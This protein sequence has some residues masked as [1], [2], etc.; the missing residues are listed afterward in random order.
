MIFLP[1]RAGKSLIV[2]K[3]F[4]AFALGKHPEWDVVCTTYG[5]ELGDDFGRSVRAVLNDSLYHQIFPQTQ[6][7]GGSNAADRM[8]T[9]ARGSYRAVGRGGS[10]TGRGAHILIVDDPLKDRQEAD[11]ETVRES[12]WKWYSSTARTRLAPGGGI[13]VCQTRWH[14]DDLAGRLILQADS[15]PQADQWCVYKYPALAIEKELDAKGHTRRNPGEALHPARFD[16]KELNRIRAS[17]TRGVDA[18]EWQALY[19]QN[20]VPADGNFFKRLDLQ[21]Y[22]TPDIPAGCYRYISTDF[23]VST[24]QSADWTVFT[25]FGVD[26]N[27]NMHFTR[28]LYCDKVDAL[29]AIEKLLDLCKKHKPLSLFIETGPISNAIM[30]MLQKRMR[31]RAIFVPIVER[32]PD[33]DKQAR[34][35]PLQALTQQKMVFFPD[36][37]FFADVLLPQFLA[38]P[39]GKH[40]DIVDACSWGAWLISK[41]IITPRAAPL[42]VDEDAV[43]DS[44]EAMRKRCSAPHLDKANKSLFAHLPDRKKITNEDKWTLKSP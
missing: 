4:P 39:A 23:A 12:L 37:P 15:D 19:Q 5:Q 41:N 6:V 43:Q 26:T 14:E 34:A 1:P 44:Y 35:T 36:S 32:R 38:F 21:T 22:S 29:V 30:P 10:L 20:P 33:K 13:I 24:K 25:P 3:N 8:D 18:R 28:D 40:D 17:L 7:A 16:E 11:S 31:E 27:G 2:S 9:T 42:L